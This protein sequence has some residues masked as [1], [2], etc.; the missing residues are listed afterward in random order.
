MSTRGLARHWAAT[1][2]CLAIAAGGAA[3]SGCGDDDVDQAVEDIQRE[4]EKATED[5]RKKGEKAVEQ[6]KKRGEEAVEKA[7]KEAEDAGY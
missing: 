2:A 7:K 1:A 4:T 5:A 3:W 6:A